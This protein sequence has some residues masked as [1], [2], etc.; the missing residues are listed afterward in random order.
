MDFNKAFD[1]V[2]HSIL[3]AAYALDRCTLCWVKKWLDGQ[4]QRVVVNGIISSNQW[5]SAVQGSVLEPVLFNIFVDNLDYRFKCTLNK[6]GKSVDLLKVERLC[7]GIWAG[8]IDGQDQQYEVLKVKCQ[9]LPLGHNNS[10]Q[11]YRQRESGW[12]TA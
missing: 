6:L 4:T 10:M 3:L 2:S 7:R 5:C 1:T 8:R 9:I 11:H 12:E